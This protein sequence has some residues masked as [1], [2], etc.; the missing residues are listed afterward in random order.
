MRLAGA[1]TVAVRGAAVV[2]HRVGR[3]AQ[4]PVDTTVADAAGRF[5]LRFTPDTS[6]AWLLSARFA[7]IEYFSAPITAEA[8]RDGELARIV[9]L[10]RSAGAHEV[11][12]FDALPTGR[13]QGRGDLVDNTAWV[14][15]YKG[16]P[17]LFAT[18]RGGFS[19]AL[20]SSAPWLARSVGYV[21][22]S[23]GWQLLSKTHMLDERYRRAVRWRIVPFIY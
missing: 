18:G 17:M 8:W 1:D 23:D 4:G 7:G 20:A 16:T 19:L 10:G 14:D 6:A 5:R 12:V 13:Y 11:F 2:L 21:G 9:E 3:A 15:D 22:V